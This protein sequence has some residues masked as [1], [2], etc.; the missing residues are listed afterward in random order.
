MTEKPDWVRKLESEDCTCVVC[1]SCNGRGY[2]H[3]G[4][5]DDMDE[6]EDWPCDYC[7]GGISEPCD[8]CLLLEEYEREEEWW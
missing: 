4:R 2:F 1:S 3:T 5:W 7:Y 8:R 6:T